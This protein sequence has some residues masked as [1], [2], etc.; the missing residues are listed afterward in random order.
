MGPIGSSCTEIQ[1]SFITVILG[2]EVYG[3][4]RYVIGLSEN[5]Y[6][7][8]HTTL[9]VLMFDTLQIVDLFRLEPYYLKIITWVVHI[10]NGILLSH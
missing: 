2:N 5:K 4:S 9:Q 1:I 8:W 3:I 7:A 10:Y 6:Q